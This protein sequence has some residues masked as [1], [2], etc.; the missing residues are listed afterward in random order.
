MF[1]NKFNVVQKLD[2][3]K[4]QIAIE[5]TMKSVVDFSCELK[6]TTIIKMLPGI[7]IKAMIPEKTTCS[8]YTQFGNVTSEKL[9][10]LF[11]VNSAQNGSMSQQFPL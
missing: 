9:V 4:S 1:R 3:R 7:P 5:N 8:T 2:P 6:N 10:M 11:I